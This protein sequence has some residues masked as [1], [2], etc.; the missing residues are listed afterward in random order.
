MEY[1]QG[2]MAGDLQLD[3]FWPPS[4]K[5]QTFALTY[6]V[7]LITILYVVL[8]RDKGEGKEAKK[9]NAEKSERFQ[10]GVRLLIE[11][12]QKKDKDHEKGDKRTEGLP[13]ASRVYGYLWD[14]THEAT[15]ASTLGIDPAHEHLV[16]CKALLDRTVFAE[17]SKAREFTEMAKKIAKDSTESAKR[18]GKLDPEQVLEKSDDEIADE[19]WLEEHGSTKKELAGYESGEKLESSIKLA[20]KMVETLGASCLQPKTIDFLKECKEFHKSMQRTKSGA[21]K[22][23]TSLIVKDVA[24][25][26]LLSLMIGLVGPAGWAEFDRYLLSGLIASGATRPDGTWDSAK[27]QRLAMNLVLIVIIWMLSDMASN[28]LLEHVKLGFTKKLKLK[29]METLMYQ[30]FEYFEKHGAGSLQHRL[31]SDVE[32]VSES[33]LR[34]PRDVIVHNWRLAMQIAVCF[35]LAPLDV[36]LVALAPIPIIAWGSRKLM[37][38]SRKAQERGRKVQEAA[39]SG[40]H[41]VIQNIKTVRGF[42]T[43]D[44]EIL[45][46]KRAS[47]YTAVLQG[48]SVVVEAGCARLFFTIFLC[49]VAFV[50][51]LCAAKVASGAMKAEDVGV[52]CVLIGLHIQGGINHNFEL[53]PKV[54]EMLIP[55]YRII[56]HF[57][58]ESKI[59][60]NPN[61][62]GTGPTK[63]FVNSLQEMQTICKSLETVKGSKEDRFDSFVR[64]KEGISSS[65]PT[66]KDV[67][68][69]RRLLSFSIDDEKTPV[70]TVDELQEL[71]VFP[72]TLLFSR[73]QAPPKFEGNVEFK[74]VEFRYPVDLR[75]KVLDGLSFT[76][77]KGTKVGLCGEAG[78]GKSTT[79]LLLQR[80]FD[81]EPSG[82]PILIDGID[83]RKYNVHFLRRRICMVAQQTVLFKTTVRENIWY[84]MQK[85]PPEEEI[86]AA[87]KSAQALDFISAKPD[88]LLTLL[89]E[90]GGGFSGGQMQRLAIARALIRKPD[91]ILLDEATAALDPVNERAVQDTL[92]RVMKGYT[93]LAIAHRLTTIKDSDKIV[94]LD[95]GKKVEEGTHDALLKIPVQFD[96][97]EDG[98]KKVKAGFYHHQWETQFNEKGLTVAQMQEKIQQLQMEIKAHEA[99][100]EKTN[101]RM[102]KWRLAGKMAKY[103]SKFSAGHTDATA[104]IQEEDAEAENHE[105]AHNE[106]SAASMEEMIRTVSPT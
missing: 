69:G 61:I 12:V 65:T 102:A 94:V 19:K 95:K 18:R 103:T 85:Q 101:A 39:M 53:L 68:V 49:N 100:I 74:N 77:E 63:V 92:D 51:Y 98:S 47:D 60:P 72:L 99:K 43:E 25:M 13:E 91:V 52:V 31:N 23:I 6:I 33:L 26:W 106:D 34:L 16:A 40:T 90:T 32:R 59:E 44:F 54:M 3:N 20:E 41:D 66:E 87:L 88:K 1:L 30:D 78:C 50:A 28:R 56:D 14:D 21:L 64:A 96:V 24:P 93:T 42:A 8:G 81:P 48:R 10:Q 22:M 4:E 17:L 79:F 11:D 7:T 82:G 84:G 45:K 36:V 105:E 5:S 83:M 57:S 89:T 80:L 75:K 46:Y 27:S 62:P 15:T 70:F 38:Y 76:V 86:I 35:R 58:A 73:K 2:I 29:F 55:L 67:K 37:K 104:A 71:R 9:A 97:K